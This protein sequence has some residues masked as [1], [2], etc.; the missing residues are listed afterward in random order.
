MCG[1]LA[2]SC[3]NKLNSSKA[4]KLNAFSG[5]GTTKIMH[6]QEAK[7]PKKTFL[8]KQKHFS[9]KKYLGL[10]VKGKPEAMF[11][12]FERLSSSPQTTQVIL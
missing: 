1:T 7:T 2:T 8:S 9:L 12:R 4:T 5:F 11:S 6:C 10:S 3:H